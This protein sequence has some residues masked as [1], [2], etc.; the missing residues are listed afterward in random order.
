MFLGFLV[1]LMKL[2]LAKPLN[3]VIGTVVDEYS[4]KYEGK[5]TIIWRSQEQWDTT[6]WYQ[7]VKLVYIVGFKRNHRQEILSY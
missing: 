1:S 6:M 2:M 3:R 4:C 5:R 7:P